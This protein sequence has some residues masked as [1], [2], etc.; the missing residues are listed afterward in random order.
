MSA[1]ESLRTVEFRQT[2]RGYHIDDVDEY[3]ERVAVEA[4]G[5]QEQLRQAHERVRQATE[6]ITQLESNRQGAP[7]AAPAPP[8]AADAAAGNESLQRTLALAQ[9]FVEQ[10]E[11]EAKAQATATVEEAERR[12]RS[13]VEEAEQRARAMA[14]ES[15]KRLRDE[16][17]RLEALRGKLAGDVETI[18]RHLD[19]ERA[20]LRG[21]LGEMLHWIDETL[22]PSATLKPTS[23]SGSGD[24]RPRE[25]ASVATPAAA[26]APSAGPR[27]GA[28][29]S[30]AG[31]NVPN[32]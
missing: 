16:V 3:L 12:A 32:R 29:Q 19:A 4:E 28:L 9:K 6:R 20:R 10:T 30:L 5:L 22:Q 31:G 11:A 18:S 14:E 23:S 25:Q 27:P 17:A 24:D 26:G 1:L 15:E 21:A 7:S 13:L 8:P 2:L